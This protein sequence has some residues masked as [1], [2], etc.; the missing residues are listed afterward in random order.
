MKFVDDDDDDDSTV[1]M[2]GGLLLVIVWWVIAAP[3]SNNIAWPHELAALNELRIY[4]HLPS[5]S[6]SLADIHSPH[7]CTKCNSSSIKGRCTNFISLYGLWSSSMPCRRYVN[8]T[9][10]TRER[11]SAT[12]R[13]TAGM[14]RR[15]DPRVWNSAQH[16]S[17]IRRFT[18]T[19]AACSW[20]ALVMSH[21]YYDGRLTASGAKPLHSDGCVMNM[22]PSIR[23][24]IYTISVRTWQPTVNS[25]SIKTIAR[26]ASITLLPRHTIRPRLARNSA[27]QTARLVLLRT[28]R[29]PWRTSK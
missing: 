12:R 5:N 9:Q 2:I 18:T 20:S 29:T 28:L 13:W 17:H 7:W 3:H 15:S 8:I 6:R 19:Y 24:H 25:P 27:K 26:V 11:R 22:C 21:L 16:R 14:R 23:P 10:A 1:W 4:S